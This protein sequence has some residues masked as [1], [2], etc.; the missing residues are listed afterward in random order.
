MRLIRG[1]LAVFALVAA[2]VLGGLSAAVADVDDFTFDDLTVD[3]TLIRAD[4]GT[5]R[6]RVVERFVARFPEVDQNRG[7]RRS[8]PDTYNGQPLRPS[9]VSVTDEDGRERP[10]DVETDD[11]VF[12]VVSRADSYLH[13]VQ[14]FVITYDLQ[15]V[16]WDF[17]DTGLEFYWDVNGVDWWQPFE[18]VTAR[19]HLD[20]DLA[21][22]G[23][24]PVHEALPAQVRA[25][26]VRDGADLGVVRERLPGLLPRDRY[27]A[28]PLSGCC[29]P[30]RRLGR[31]QDQAAGDR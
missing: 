16:T 15:N 7:I 31:A 22:T 26:R 8:I 24:G 6:M 13:G 5:S 27:Q 12:S 28:P 17:P 18:S 23:V 9:L 3:Y 10:S 19:L 14:T 21:G 20:G 11:G 30:D 1:L 29:A 4:D 2:S 25:C